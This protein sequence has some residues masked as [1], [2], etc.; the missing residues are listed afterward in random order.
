MPEEIERIVFVTRPAWPAV[1]P[2]YPVESSPKITA[3]TL[4]NGV[5]VNLV[6]EGQKSNPVRRTPREVRGFLETNLISTI[7]KI[8]GSFIIVF[9]PTPNYYLATGRVT[10][11]KMK[12]LA[13]KS[14]FGDPEKHD[15]KEQKSFSKFG[16]HRLSSFFRVG[17][18]AQ[19]KAFGVEK[20]FYNQLRAE[21]P[22]KLICAQGVFGLSSIDVAQELHVW[23][24]TNNVKLSRKAVVV[25]MGSW[26]ENCAKAFPREFATLRKIKSTVSI[27]GSISIKKRG[28]PVK[29]HK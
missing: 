11:A 9:V 20:K 14:G 3:P 13:E 28:R 10:P 22:G 21:F 7:R 15:K 26:A 27:H 16:K 19:R 1:V 2:R 18:S 23:L 17:P 5:C 4:K 6:P 12:I 29:I 8:K 25:G 24:E